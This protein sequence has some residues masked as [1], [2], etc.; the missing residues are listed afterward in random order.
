MSGSLDGTLRIWYSDSGRTRTIE[1][2]REIKEE[3]MIR[4]WDP[5]FRGAEFILYMTEV[6][7]E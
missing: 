4:A 6:D 1:R 5:G 3:L 7:A 2:T